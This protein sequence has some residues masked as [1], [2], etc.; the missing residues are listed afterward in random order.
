[1]T[2]TKQVTGKVAGR[3]WTLEAGKFAFQATGAVTALVGETEVLTTATVN[4][5]VRDGQDFFPLTVDVEEKMYA[6]GKI[7]GSF[8]R[9][10]GR[11]SEKGILLCRLIDRP[12]RPAFPDGFRNEIQVVNTI[13]SSDQI[14]PVDIVA[15]NA[16]SASLVVSGMPFDGP[17]GAVRMALIDGDWVTNPNY[18]EIEQAV[19]EMVI[20]GRRNDAGEIDIMMVEAGA[21]ENAWQLIEA[22]A[23]KPTEDAI[24]DAIEAAKDGIGELIDLQ[25][26]LRDAVSPEALEFETFSDYEDDIYARVE[27]IATPQV[28]ENI[29]IANKKERGA[30]NDDLAESV[31]ETFTSAAEDGALDP[32]VAKQ[33]KAAL[34][35]LE[36]SLVRRRIVEDGVRIDG[37]GTADLRAL[38]AEVGVVP[39]SHGSGLFQ[40]GETQVLNIL[41]LGMLR[42][43]AMIDTI[44]PE[45]SKRYMHQYN[46]PPFSTGEAG[47]MRG[48][49]RREIGHGALAERALVPVVPDEEEFPYALRLVS[50]V[51]SS[52]GST[53]MASVCS[54]SLS[55]LDGGVP[56][57]APVAGIAMGLVNDG[58][59][60]VPLTDILG[61]E[62]A[63]GDM[64][65]KV[66]GTSEFVTALQL[67]TKIQG[68]PSDVLARALAQAHDARTTI[69]GVMADAIDGPRA[70]M[71]ATA[72]QI[73]VIEVPPDKIGDVIGP[74]GKI[75]QE[76]T[77][78]TGA[79]IDIDD[80]G[81]VRVG[82]ADQE[83]VSEAIDWIDSIVN[84]PLPEVD[85]EYDGRVVN[86]TDFGAFISILPG[87]DGLV[88][89]SK[90]GGSN[91]VDSVSSILSVGDQVKVKVNEIDPQGRVN[92][93]PVDGPDGFVGDGDFSGGG[94]GRG[95]GRGGDRGG[96]GGGGGRGRD[97][98]GGGGGRNRN[99][100]RDDRGGGGGRNRNRDR[101]DRGGGGGGNRN[102]DRDDRGGGGRDR[103][104]DDRGGDKRDRDGGSKPKRE[105]VSFEDEFERQSD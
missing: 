86:I 64:D 3:E 31:I 13:L 66:A 28:K 55:L 18:T 36:K 50:E 94:G 80:D 83:A 33:I 49:K 65:F 54:S 12:L 21:T 85:K 45:E 78:E 38:S 76:I 90:I 71:R 5:G 35:S 91:R 74:R 17:I 79:D 10:E 26:E 93:W 82:G 15:L 103:D 29:Q 95:G 30:A 14:D 48:P 4:E 2:D 97:R 70:E 7:P 58:D 24:V 87:R 40:R 61:V 60:F 62:D 56:L 46:M 32:S 43:V 6:V 81:T 68:L 9:R 52:N 23:A 105:T 63:Y 27:E 22:G 44:Y 101:D 51:L 42:M 1:M 75:I 11:T 67:D 96:R 89:I 37:R 84:P 88:H 102:R 47:F 77:R 99:R 39:R 73:T 19:F 104:R 92:L 100:D 25:A 59:N 57:R 69:L 34:R 41:T 98:D 20:A 16:A 8:F 53:S 72:P